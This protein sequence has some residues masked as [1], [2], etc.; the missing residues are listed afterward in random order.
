M[1]DDQVEKEFRLEAQE[2]AELLK[3]IAESLEDE[4]QVALEGDDWKVFKE[5]EGKIPLRVFADENELEIGFKISG[6]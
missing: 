2:A 6:K 5:N 4:E 1:K 3:D